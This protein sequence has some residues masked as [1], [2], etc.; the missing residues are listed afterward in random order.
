MATGYPGGWPVTGN[1][2]TAIV[3]ASGGIGGA[4][5]RALTMDGRVSR[6]WALSR[7][8]PDRLPKDAVWVPIDVECEDSIMEAARTVK[9]GGRPLRLTLVASGTLHDGSGLAPEK[10]WRDLDA[11]RLGKAFRINAI[12][13]ALVAKHFLPLL[14]ATGK[15]VFACLS[16]RVG[17]ISDNALGGWYGY[18]ASKAALNQLIRTASI[19]LRRR[20]PH[21]VCIA[22]HPGTVD[23]PLSAPFAK[24]GLSVQP[25][26]IAVAR[27]LS[28][29]E[30]LA[31]DDSG[32][33]YD[34]R[35]R[36]LPW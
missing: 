15:S 30:R 12:G 35:G 10:A 14:P 21:A 28:V 8:R 13:P 27:L 33:F 31:P 32:L 34:H 29:I 9:D 20:R 2:D 6:V 11:E 16:A 19:E 26:D 17:S 22:I 1:F 18:R 3:G 5:V 25:P 7:K 24:S 4:V 23:T 36:R